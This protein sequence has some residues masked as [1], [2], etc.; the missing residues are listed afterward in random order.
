VTPQ[1]SACL[2]FGSFVC[3]CLLSLFAP[4]LARAAADHSLT[5]AV[6]PSSPLIEREAGEQL[7]NFDFAVTNRGKSTLRLTEIE[8]SVY[9]AKQQLLSR[10]TVN[11]NGLSPG[12]SII[13]KPLISAGE[14]LDIFNPFYSFPEYFPIVRLDYAFRYVREDNDS[15][16]EANRHRLPMDFD[17][18]VKSTVTPQKFLS[19]TNLILPIQGKL[20]I[21]EGHDFYAH[22]RRVPL[23]DPKVSQMGLRAN[24]N[25]FALDFEIVDNDGS[26]YHGDPYDKSNWYCYGASIYAPGAGKVIGAENG[27]PDNRFEGKSVVHPSLPANADAKGLGNYVL[28]DHGNDEYSLMLHMQPGS[29]LVRQG[30]TVRQGQKIGRIGFSGDTIFPHLHYSLLSGPE[31]SQ[32]EGIPA[33]FSE[34]RRLL[35]SQAIESTRGA[36][37]SGDLVESEARYEG[38]RRRKQQAPI[39]HVP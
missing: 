9:G 31:V 11:S 8:V 30:E 3:V 6:N 24:S 18:E 19:K 28:I 15:D 5:I 4:C 36:I 37:D 14:T 29:V 27:I 32:E 35:G 39:T 21:W 13:A 17:L 38:Q 25:R 26:M 34:Y 10:K 22:H 16:R 12:I 20:F 23:S 1:R 33:Y 7:L 2:R